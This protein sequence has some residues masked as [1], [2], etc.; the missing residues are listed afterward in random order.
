MVW[1]GYS[2]QLKTESR[3]LAQR[4]LH[5]SFCPYMCCQESSRGR[6]TDLSVM[7]ALGE[8]LSDSAKWW[9]FGS[10]A[11]SGVCL[12]LGFFSLKSGITKKQALCQTSGELG[13]KDA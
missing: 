12:G 9:S 11:I 6:Q 7:L 8:S 2:H 13:L 4:E 10:F 3:L 1:V 5:V